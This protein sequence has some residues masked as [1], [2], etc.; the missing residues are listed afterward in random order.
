MNT[1][2]YLVRHGQT[3]WNVEKRIQGLCSEPINKTGKQQAKNV[4]KIFSKIQID[5]VY[6]SPLPRCMQ[7]TEIIAPDKTI[8]PAPAFI[9]RIF[10]KLEGVHGPSLKKIIPDLHEQWAKHG[11][12][13]R[14]P[15]GETIREVT[16]RVAN[17]FEELVRSHPGKRVLLVTHGMVIKCLVHWLHG[18]KPENVFHQKEIENAEVIRVEYAQQGKHKLHRVKAL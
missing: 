10:G 12:D 17:A 16:R 14:P 6:S 3:Q 2:V 4:A 1:V 8:M 7:T 18:G 5:F 9:E 13:W 15:G 11:I